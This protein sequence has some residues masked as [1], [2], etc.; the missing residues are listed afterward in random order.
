MRGD[1][2]GG[3]SERF[4]SILGAP[5]EGRRGAACVL[6]LRAPCAGDPKRRPE[7]PRGPDV[8]ERCGFGGARGLGVEWAGGDGVPAWGRADM[9]CVG[10]R[11][12]NGACG[13]VLRLR[14]DVVRAWIWL[15]RRGSV[16]AT[17]EHMGGVVADDGV[18]PRSGCTEGR[19]E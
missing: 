17:G 7:P 14:H 2:P 15:P 4:F 6:A 12:G 5:R 18:I 16:E 10:A 3:R 19:R 1:T 9:G 8:G 13:G 11:G